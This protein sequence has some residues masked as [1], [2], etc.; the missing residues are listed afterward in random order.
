MLNPY[1]PPVVQG[2]QGAGLGNGQW[3]DIGYA[4]PFDVTITNADQLLTNQ[5]LALLSDADF[6]FRGL[7]FTSTGNFSVRIYDGDQYALSDGLVMSQ[8]LTSTPGDPFPWFPEVWYPAGG[9][10]LIDIQDTSG[11]GGNII[12][13]LFIG[14]N[15]YRLGQN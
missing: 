7:M 1:A 5:A 6:V 13:L 15:R 11:S 9:K 4:Y 12:E 2:I 8:N 10:I 3:V 14:A